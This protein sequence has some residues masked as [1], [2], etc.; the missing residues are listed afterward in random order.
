MSENGTQNGICEHTRG[1]ICNLTMDQ[2]QSP[3]QRR[4]TRPT[5]HGCLRT[6]QGN[7]VKQGNIVNT[8]V[9][10][11]RPIGNGSRKKVNQY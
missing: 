1:L 11:A 3:Q 2:Q 4:L 9:V 8:N 7:I 5:C 10:A 6:T